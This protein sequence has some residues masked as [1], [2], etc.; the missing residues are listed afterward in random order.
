[1]GSRIVL[2]FFA[3]LIASCSGRPLTLAECRTVA[4]KEV[5]SAISLAPA[6]DAPSL[7]EHLMRNVASSTAQC[8]AGHTYRR[9]D[10]Q[11]M[12]QA[13]DPR[14]TRECIQELSA[15]IYH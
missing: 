5:G 10:Y 13:G 12:I 9:S 3:V 1:M 8:V 2:A 7:K 4:S 11:C 15:R 6:A 14:E